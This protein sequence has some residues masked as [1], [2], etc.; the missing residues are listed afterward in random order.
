MIGNATGAMVVTPLRPGVHLLTN[1]ELN[2]PECPRIAKSYALFDQARQLLKPGSLPK[3]RRALRAILAD[4]ST[5]LDPRSQ[6]LPNSLCVHTERFGTR[7]STL[8]M[9]S[10]ADQCFRMWHADG[11]PCRAAYTEVPLPARNS[12]GQP[13]RKTVPSRAMIGEET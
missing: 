13:N 12:A 5:P 10:S 4:H 8:L 11:P 2:D 7:S 1:L 6:E 9:Y 3:V